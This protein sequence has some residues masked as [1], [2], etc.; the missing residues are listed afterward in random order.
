MRD[1]GKRGYQ[2]LFPRVKERGVDEREGVGLLGKLL[3]AHAPPV[4]RALVGAHGA[5]ARVSREPIKARARSRC[6]VTQAAIAALCGRVR[7]ILSASNIGP[8]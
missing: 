2:Y 7:C 5:L 8:C 6:C 4:P 1:G 3:V